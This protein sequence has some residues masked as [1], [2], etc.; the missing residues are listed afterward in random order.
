MKLEFYRQ[1][2]GKDSNIR[3]HENPSIWEPTCIWK[4]RRTH[5]QTDRHDD[6][7]GRYL[8]F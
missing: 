3:F 2:V 5:G 4:E 7:N 6:A 8:Q 1:I